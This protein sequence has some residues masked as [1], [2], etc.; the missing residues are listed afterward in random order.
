MDYLRRGEHLEDVDQQ[1]LQTN[2]ADGPVGNK[3]SN[4]YPTIP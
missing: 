1:N 3:R 2:H 4:I